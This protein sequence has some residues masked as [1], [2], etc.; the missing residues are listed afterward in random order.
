MQYMGGKARIAGKL[1]EVMLA[2]T[3]NRSHYLEPF[4]GGAYV[5]ARMAPHFRYPAA[6]DIMPGLASYWAAIQCGWEPPAEMTLEEYQSLKDAPMS[7]LKIFAGF[8]CSFGGKW[9]GGYGKQNVDRKHPTGHV[10][11][12]SR[13]TSMAKRT[14]LA[15][16]LLSECSYEMWVPGPGT[17]VYCDPPYAGTTTYKGTDAFDSDPF[18]KTME[19]WADRGA[20]VFVS[21]YQA[22]SNWK[23]IYEVDTPSSLKSGDNTGRVTEKLFAL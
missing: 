5:L 4:M 18:W 12:G 17:V 20:H 15:N 14:A 11:H 6:G 22:P 19:R 23:A 3:P 21:E 10:S 9:F 13:K 1:A 16:V 8:G 2:T 7:P